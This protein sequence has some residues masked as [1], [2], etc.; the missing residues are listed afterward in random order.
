M[1]S[2]HIQRGDGHAKLVELLAWLGTP[3]AEEDD[4][5][6]IKRAGGGDKS[7]T[8]VWGK[9]GGVGKFAI[10]GGGAPVTPAKAAKLT[11]G[12]FKRPRLCIAA[13]CKMG[14]REAIRIF[15]IS[16]SCSLLDFARRFWNQ[17]FTWVSV[18]F[19][20]FENSARSAMDRYCFSRNFFSNCINCC[21]VKGV[22]GFLFGLCLRK[23]QRIGPRGFGGGP[24]TETIKSYK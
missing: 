8:D 20:L 6:V 11:A 3:S 14:G 21:V 4:P 18:K 23:V 17:I 7:P 19:K 24:E 5:E 22:R 12:V 13:A 1:Q 9:P 15:S 2:I 10:N 16:A